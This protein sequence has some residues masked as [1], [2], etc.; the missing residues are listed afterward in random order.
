[1]NT[2][3]KMLFAS[4]VL[5]IALAGC[6]ANN[7]NKK[8]AQAKNDKDNDVT[9]KVTEENEHPEIHIPNQPVSSFWFPQDLLEWDAEEDPDVPYNISTVELAER[10][11]K[12]KLPAANDGQNTETEVVALSIMN[13]STSGNPPHG[14]NSFDNNMFSY[15]Q[16][17]DQ[18]VY[19]G[20]SAGEGLIVP[21]SPDVTN[22]AHLNGVPI[23]GTVFFPP[24]HYSGKME[25]LDT[26]LQKDESGNFPM[27]DKLIEVADLY[28]FDGWFINQETEGSEEE[29]LTKE[30]ADLMMAFI[31]EYKEKSDNNLE[32]MYYDAMTV[33]GKVDWQNALNDENALYLVDKDG[34]NLAD[35]MFL[36]FWWTN[37]DLAEKE[38]LKSSNAKAEEI[39]FDPYKLYAGVDVQA[40]GFATP[41]RWDLFEKSANETYTSL[42]LYAADWAY[43]SSESLEDYHSKENLFWV[44]SKGDPRELVDATGTEWRGISRYAIE[45]SSLTTLPFTTNFNLGNGYNF[46]IDGEKV[47]ELDWNNRSV[48]DIMPTYRWILDH[49]GNNQLTAS[50]DYAQAYY[51]GNSI[52][53]RG[54]MEENKVSTV[55]L[56]SADLPISKDMTFTT[57]AKA[58]AETDLQ[59]VLT[60]DDGSEEIIKA[61]KKVQDSWTTITYDVSKLADQSIRTIS[62]QL[63]TAE[64]KD[65]YEFHLGNITIS[66]GKEEKTTKV[67]KV[68]VEDTAFDEDAML[69]GVRLTWEVD[70]DAHHYEVYRVNEDKSKS[71]LGV[72]KSTNYYAHTLPRLD[73]T[74]QSTFEIVP[75]TQF[76]ERGTGSQATMDWPDNSM[77]KADFTASRT[78]IAPGDSITFTDLSSKNTENVEWTFEGADEE[79]SKD[80]EPTITYSNEGTFKVTLKSTNESGE[81]EKTIEKYILVSKDVPEE[82]AL[83]SQGKNATAP[84]YVNDQEAPEFALDGDTSS[85]WC[86]VGDGPHEIIID[87]EQVKTIS[88]VY[89]AHAEA[90]GE[91]SD[92]NTKAY[93]ILVSE[94][95]T[96]YQEV[97]NITK[98]SLG[99]TVDTFAPVE[100]RYVKL[101]IVKPTQGSDSAA[102]IYEIGVHGLQ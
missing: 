12:D 94:D 40:N 47:S 1:M 93:K 28:G 62:Y 95:G 68:N 74:N 84:S 32:L 88:E 16:Y 4:I 36:N 71:L 45:K 20:G 87:L 92:M 101:S 91:S 64:T 15:W 23:L 81:D 86:A 6:S 37:V 58:N 27:V 61:D 79:S 76:L 52:K 21:P 63:S 30:H 70:E 18:M 11:A 43:S 42:G 33:D 69:A 96:D 19:W 90:G 10:V 85:K 41:I 38:L 55:K 57:T 34:E 82:L 60:L 49:E 13:S 14:I 65:A 50:I 2:F 46:F 8:D 98:N 7:D 54:N 80:R 78:L 29:P 17:I 67:T 66:D 89:I 48:A 9:Y 100:A 22:A 83:L 73:E 24:M 77:P 72:A 102:R 39:G 44:N 3:R 31:K 59:L 25:W 97:A 26:F 35:S 5:V 99:E 56:Y 51:G 75:V 53:F